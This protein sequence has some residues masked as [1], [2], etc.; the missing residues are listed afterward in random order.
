MTKKNEVV[1]PAPVGDDIDVTEDG[2][3]EPPPTTIWDYL[4][5][6]KGHQAADK[7][8]TI[9]ADIKNTATETISSERRA[10]LEA[11]IKLRT[12]QHKIQLSVF[13]LAMIVVAVLSFLGKLDPGV[14][15]LLGTMVGYFFGKGKG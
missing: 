15:M 9:L 12:F 10:R 14:S 11:E 6:D 8:I 1:A 3:T 7:V 4:Q 5:T 2:I 13:F